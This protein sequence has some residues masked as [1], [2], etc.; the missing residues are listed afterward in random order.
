M[1]S[2]EQVKNRAGRPPQR[3]DSFNQREVADVTDGTVLGEYDRYNM[4]RMLTL[5]A[6]IPARISAAAVGGS[7][8]R[9][10]TRAIPRPR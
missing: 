10:A 7:T 8:R 5:G 4:R 1:D 9:F 2:L 3:A 6:N